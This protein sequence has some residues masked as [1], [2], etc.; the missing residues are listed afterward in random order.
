MTVPTGL[1]LTLTDHH[2]MALLQKPL[3]AQVFRMTSLFE[4]A[5]YLTQSQIQGSEVK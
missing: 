4:K 1:V 2:S 3:P 5:T